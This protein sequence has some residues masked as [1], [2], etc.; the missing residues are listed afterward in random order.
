MLRAGFDYD[1]TDSLDG[2]NAFSLEYTRGFDAFG[3]SEGEY[4]S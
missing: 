2:F 3:A 1:V 4:P